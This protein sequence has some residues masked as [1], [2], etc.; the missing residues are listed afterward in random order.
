MLHAWA[1][2]GLESAQKEFEEKYYNSAKFSGKEILVFR[3]Y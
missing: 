2:F 3:M 1:K